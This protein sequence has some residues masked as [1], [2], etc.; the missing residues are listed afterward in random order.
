[1]SDTEKLVYDEWKKAIITELKKKENQ[2]DLVKAVT[3]GPEEYRERVERQEDNP[4][5]VKKRMLTESPILGEQK[6]RYDGEN[7]V[8]DFDA[9]EKV[10]RRKKKW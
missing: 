8:P 7:I 5:I 1:M 2:A 10:S 9:H 3:R 6:F 4:E